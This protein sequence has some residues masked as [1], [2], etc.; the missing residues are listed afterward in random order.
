[1]SGKRRRELYRELKGVLG[2]SPSKAVV[3]N[4]RVV[5]QDEFR[6]WKRRK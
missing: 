3:R 6:Q 1:M 2:R 4:G 5:Q